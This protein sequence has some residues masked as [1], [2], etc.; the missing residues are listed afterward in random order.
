MASYDLIFNKEGKRVDSTN[1]YESKLSLDELTRKIMTDFNT[2]GS[3]SFTEDLEKI[4]YDRDYSVRKKTEYQQ[5]TVT[6]RECVDSF[7]VSDLSERLK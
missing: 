5:R 2:V 3:F 7:K 4:D 1:R 6:F